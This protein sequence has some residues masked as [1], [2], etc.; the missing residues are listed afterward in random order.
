MCFRARMSDG[1]TRTSCSEG[2]SL[3]EQILESGDADKK[4][5]RA[6][7]LTRNLLPLLPV[8]DSGLLENVAEVDVGVQKVGVQRDG[9]LEVVDGQ[10]DFLTVGGPEFLSNDQLLTISSS[11][12][13][14]V[15]QLIH[16]LKSTEI[17]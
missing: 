8:K 14:V 9:L 12:S 10:P 4:V 5:L 3:P 11:L 1:K 16:R 7:Q 17:S 13:T 2:I 15:V 6:L